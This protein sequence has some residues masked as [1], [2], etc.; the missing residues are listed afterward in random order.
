MT[1]QTPFGTPGTPGWDWLPRA[2]ARNTATHSHTRYAVPRSSHS[3]MLT[4]M[5]KDALESVCCDAEVKADWSDS[6]DTQDAEDALERMLPPDVPRF[7]MSPVD[8]CLRS[9]RPWNG[10]KEGR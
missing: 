7:S 10:E 6:V 8:R 5:T 9:L 1:K 2:R 4:S 3:R